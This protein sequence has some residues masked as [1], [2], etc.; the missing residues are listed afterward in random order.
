MPHTQTHLQSPLPRNPQTHVC[1]TVCLAQTFDF[2]ALRD[3]LLQASGSLIVH[4]NALI[5][6]GKSCCSIIFGYGVVVHWNVDGEER[7]RRHELLLN[8][9]IRPENEPQEDSFTYQIG[10][11]QD[12]IQHDH[13][14]LR[15]GNPRALLALSHAM[16]QSIKLASFENQIIATIKE[17][18]HL[19]QSLARE[20]KIRLS[21][22]KMAQIRGRL[23]LARS[24]IILNYDLLDIP[25][26]FWEHPEY[27]AIYS[28]AAN[29]LEIQQRTEVLSKKLETLHELLEM[30]ADEQKHQHSSI[31]EWII[32]WLITVETVLTIW[33]KL[34]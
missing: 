15:D 3:T 6:D 22:R 10:R 7:R 29:Y 19:P 18:S 23:Y 14:E 26:F 4:R 20:G 12:R 1:L 13:L 11:D 32:I 33:S 8:H 9:A 30:L 31:L 25:E 2:A 24:D 27:Q 5:I 34:F 21:R 28:M 17:T 16:A